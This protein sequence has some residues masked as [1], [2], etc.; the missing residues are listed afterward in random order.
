MRVYFVTGASGSGKTTILKRLG[1]KGMEGL[2]MY[3]FD[4]IGVPTPEEMNEKF[5]SG[6]NWQKATTEYWVQKMKTEAIDARKLLLDGQMRVSFITDA[7]TK[8]GVSNFEVILFDCSDEVRRERLTRRGQ[9][10]L[11]NS[12]MMNWAV[13][14]R[15]EAKHGN[16]RIIDTTNQS[17][18]ETLRDLVAELT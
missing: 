15:N 6:E 2:K 4:S 13:Y 14:L 11:A 5:G 17:E 9:S 1:S 7:C 3:Y 10:E 16:H 12:D 8:Y 18:E